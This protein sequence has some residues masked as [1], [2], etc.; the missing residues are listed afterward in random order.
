MKKIDKQIADRYYHIKNTFIVGY[1]VIW[2]L[3]SF[4][5]VIAAEK[6]AEYSFLGMPLHY[7]MG[8]QGAIVTFIVLLFINAIVSDILD[9]KFEIDN[10]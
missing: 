10:I 7:Y 1:F 8:A 6:L 2:A 3:V 4:G 9:K 5:G